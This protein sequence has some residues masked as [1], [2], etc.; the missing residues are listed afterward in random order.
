MVMGL[1]IKV[2]L[3]RPAKRESRNIAGIV[4]IILRARKAAQ[5]PIGR[6]TITRKINSGIV[7]IILRDLKGEAEATG[8]IAQ[9]PRV[10]PAQV[11]I[12]AGN[13][14]VSINRGQA[15]SLSPFFS[16]IMPHASRN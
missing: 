15:T 12:D 11:Q 8:R 10:G 5:A 9:D 14:S 6:K 4:T 3:S 2:N 16:V 1:W 7:T 13:D